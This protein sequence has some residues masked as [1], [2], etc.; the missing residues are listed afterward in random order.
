MIEKRILKNQESLLPYESWILS[1]LAKTI[2]RMDEGMEEYDFS[3]SG[4]DLL[5][6]IR[7]EYADFAI[8]AYKIEKDRSTLGKDV[9]SLCILDIIAMLHPYAPHITEMLYGHITGGKILATSSWP[10]TLLSTDEK[11]DGSM[12]RIGEIIRIIRSLRAESGI[13]P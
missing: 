13:K 1:R 7:D 11:T 6:F 5:S 9:M 8:E 10:E 2:A 3:L 12:T 4:S